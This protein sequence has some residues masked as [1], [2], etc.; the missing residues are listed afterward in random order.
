MIFDL[1][2][3]SHGLRTASLELDASFRPLRSLDLGYFFCLQKSS[4]WGLRP[5]NRHFYSLKHRRNVFTDLPDTVFPAV[6][7]PCRFQLISDVPE[8]GPPEILRQLLSQVYEPWNRRNAAQRAEKSLQ[9]PRKR[10]K[11]H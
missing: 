9:T 6:S 4:F 11:K 8:N 10:L 3:A 5:L 2:L 1:D 7:G